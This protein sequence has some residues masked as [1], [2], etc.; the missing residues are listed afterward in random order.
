LAIILGILKSLAKAALGQTPYRLS[1][2]GF[3]SR[4]QAHEELLSGLKARGFSPQHVIDGGANVGHFALM[5]RTIWPSATVHMIEPQVS[6]KPS[7]DRIARRPGFIVHG[8]AL[9][10]ERGVLRIA[11]D[12]ATTS[13]DAHITFANDLD[14]ETNLQQTIEVPSGTI[15]NLFA[16]IVRPNDGV[17]L[18]LD[19]QGFELHALKGGTKLLQNIDAVLMEVSF[20]AQAYEPPIAQLVR[21]F[22]DRGFDLHDIAALAARR[23]DN[24]AHQGEFLIV[25]RSSG[26]SEDNRWG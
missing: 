6:C 23:R 7:L 2:S 25:N 11:A 20:F 24:R 19:L 14:T 22:D 3:S 16:T 18:K 4:F 8:V 26:L 12:P 1:R 5:L 17:L 15:D 21:F 10:E 13:T 9:G